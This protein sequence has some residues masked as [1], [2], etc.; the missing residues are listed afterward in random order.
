[1]SETFAY[2]LWCQVQTQVSWDA[3]FVPV[4]EGDNAHVCSTLVEMEERVIVFGFMRAAM[5]K[6]DVEYKTRIDA[7]RVTAEFK[8]KS[9]KRI[10]AGRNPIEDSPLFGGERQGGLF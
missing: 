10:D 4:I 7:E 6:A 8:T 2:N 1:M 9:T 3:A 5:G